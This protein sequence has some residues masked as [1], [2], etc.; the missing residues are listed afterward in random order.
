M[1]PIVLAV[2]VAALLA[3]ANSAQAE[4]VPLGYKQDTGPYPSVF[5]APETLERAESFQVLVTADPIQELE[6]TTYISCIRGAESVSTQP[7]DKLVT[8][9]YSMTILPTLLEPDSC[10]ITVSAEALFK[11][12]KEGTVRVEVIGN[13]R[14]APP[15][16][17]VIPPPPY[18]TQ[19]S[20]P[21]WL[22][23]GEAKIHGSISCSRAKAIA[24]SA[25]RK[26]ARAGNFVSTR[27]YNCHRSELRSQATIRC[28]RGATIIRVTGK[29]KGS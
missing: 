13:R 6:Y 17:P 10:W 8:P 18:W 20:L 15:P 16:P 24:R 23:S 4:S 29:L 19:C 3:G 27:G 22:K 12:S 28:I 14:P 9:P 21:T 2:S 11:G 7:P 26:P 5:F 25:W 1:R